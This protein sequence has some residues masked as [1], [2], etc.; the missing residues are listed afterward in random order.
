MSD[1]VILEIVKTTG[2]IVTAILST[3]AV[4]WTA[5]NNREVKEGRK[6]TQ[7]LSIKVD[8]RLSELLEVSKDNAEKLGYG[9]GVKDQKA[10][11]ASLPIKAELNIPELKVTLTPPTIPPPE[12]K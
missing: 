4:V 3:I 5:R 7:E 1:T 11:T 12:K 10:E 6:E 2:I 9:K 8:G